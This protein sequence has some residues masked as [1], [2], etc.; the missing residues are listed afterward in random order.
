MLSE[1]HAGGSEASAAC[2]KRDSSEEEGQ[3][4]RLLRVVQEAWRRQQ[5]AMSI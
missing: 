4:R 3:G 1:S 2:K 5:H